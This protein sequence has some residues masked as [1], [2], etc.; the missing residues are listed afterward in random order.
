MVNLE[1]LEGIWWKKELLRGIWYE[2]ENYWEVFGEK[3]NNYNNEND[4]NICIKTKEYLIGFWTTSY[5]S[6]RNRQAHKILHDKEAII[7]Q[8][9]L[10]DNSKYT[11]SNPKSSNIFS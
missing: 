1:R 9:Y 2:K 6:F 3:S 8:N 5:V 10:L 4:S 7:N 11:S